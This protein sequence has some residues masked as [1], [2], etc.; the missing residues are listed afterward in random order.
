MKDDTLASHFSTP[1]H[2]PQTDIAEDMCDAPDGVTEA[3][4]AEG[5]GEV[6]EVRQVVTLQRRR[7]GESGWSITIEG[8]GER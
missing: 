7:N 5:D 8:E 6:V 4:V 1:E 3:A 2:T